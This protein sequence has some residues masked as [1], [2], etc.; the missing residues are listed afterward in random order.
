MNDTIDT[1]K[2]ELARQVQQQVSGSEVE[3]V[4]KNDDPRSYRVDFTK[5]REQLAFD[6]DWTVQRGIEEVHEALLA[7]VWT[8][9]YAER[10]RN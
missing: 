10:Y 7:G 6:T 5:V 8:D 3:F 9:P 4:K 2:I 1:R